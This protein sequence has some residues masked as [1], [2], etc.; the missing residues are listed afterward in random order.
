MDGWMEGWKHS[1][2]QGPSLGKGQPVRSLHFPQALGSPA[3]FTQFKAPHECLIFWASVVPHLAPG[4]NATAA[5]RE[6]VTG[7]VC[8]PSGC[9]P[10]QLPSQARPPLREL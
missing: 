1:Q 4:P 5:W 3:G 8:L 2:V 7:S 6:G 10:G 9:T